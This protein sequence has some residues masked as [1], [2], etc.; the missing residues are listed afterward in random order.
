MRD[1]PSKTSN[2][3]DIIELLIVFEVDERGHDLTS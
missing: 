1:D 2:T 3:L